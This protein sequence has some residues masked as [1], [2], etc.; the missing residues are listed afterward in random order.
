MIADSVVYVQNSNVAN[1]GQLFEL[2]IKI[3]ELQLHF[4][5]N[6]QLTKQSLKASSHS[7]GASLSI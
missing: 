3:K 5:D 4:L 7:V 1:D 6:L 2:E